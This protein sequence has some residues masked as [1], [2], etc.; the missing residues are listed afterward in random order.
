MMQTVRSRQ[1]LAGVLVSV[2]TVVVIGVLLVATTPIGCG[3]ANA[4]GLKSVTKHCLETQSTAARATVPPTPLLIPTPQPSGFYVPPPPPPYSPPASEPNPPFDPSSSSAS[5]PLPPFFPPASGTG[6]SKPPLTLSCRLPVYVGPS[7]SGGFIGFPN[8]NFAP[9]ANSGVNLPSPSPGSPS[10]PPVPQYGQGYGG[11]TYDVAFKKWV[12]VPWTSVTPDGSR[13][14]YTSPNSIYVTNVADNSQVELGDGK[15]WVI[16]AVQ[17]EGV[18]ATNPNVSGL[19]LLPYTGAPRQ[20]TTVGYW[21]AEAAGAAYGTETSA[22][23]QGVSTTINRLDIGTGAITAWFSRGSAS[24]S[25]AGFDG[26][27]KPIIFAYPFNSQGPEVWIANS[28]TNWVAIMGPSIGVFANGTPIADS[29]G[30][31]F[32]ASIQDF[33]SPGNNNGQLLYVPGSGVY[34]MTKIGAQL[35]GGCN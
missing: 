6:V 10:P 30:V 9:D 15:A 18:Y 2:V 23:P 14:A 28:P 7:G 25:V 34:L 24:S 29:H 13:Y 27:G 35:A 3:P 20:I 31:W 22:L 12:P 16:I 21:Q 4:L 19:W 26:Q 11:L 8:G 32:S 1:I 5:P 33:S 17:S